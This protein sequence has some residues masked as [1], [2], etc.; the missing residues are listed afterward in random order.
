MELFRRTYSEINLENLRHNWQQIQ[1]IARQDRFICPM[2]KA[3][4]YGHG[5]SQVAEVLVQEGAEALGVCLLE[6]GL[7]LSARGLQTDIL[8]FRGFDRRGAEAI[9]DNQLVP[10]VSQWSHLEAL[11]SVASDPVKVHLKFNTGMTRLGFE[12][13]ESEK[14]FNFFKKSKK[15]KLKALLTHLSTGD[16][17]MTENGVSQQQFKKMLEIESFFKPL[18]VYT[19]LLNSSGIMSLAWHQQNKIDSLLSQQ[20]T[21][22]FRPG[23]MLYGCHTEPQFNFV[24]LKPVMSFRSSIDTVRKVAAGQPVSY[25]GTWSSSQDSYIGV[26]LAGY[27]DGVHRL[28]SNRG[29]V[30]VQGQRCPIVGRICMDFFMVDLT[31]LIGDRDPSLLTGSEV[32]FFGYDEDG[33]LLSADHWAQEAQTINYEILTSVSS[34]VPRQYKGI[35]KA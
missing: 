15:L 20:S 2:V 11:E 6:E 17:A 22:G 31:A 19:H 26:V 24:D 34:R 8:V 30:L 25:G 10:V 3:N 33:Q 4:A 28:L 21:W 27:A 29:H 7:H 16:D 12:P 32:T 13:E 23:L 18:N 1:S 9:V 35:T 14:L 5:D